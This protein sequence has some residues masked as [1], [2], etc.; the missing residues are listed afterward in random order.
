M[1][2]TLKTQ[3][4][5]GLARWAVQLVMPREEVAQKCNHAAEPM[6]R[7][8]VCVPTPADKMGL[9]VLAILVCGEGEALAEPARPEPRPPGLLRARNSMQGRRRIAH[10]WQNPTCG[11]RQK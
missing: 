1:G 6:G 8:I 11:L 5:V 9:G 3:A 2:P 10:Q 4:S 7:A